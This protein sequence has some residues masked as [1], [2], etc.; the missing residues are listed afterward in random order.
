MSLWEF[1]AT[2]N[3]IEPDF[4]GFDVAAADGHIGKV[5][6]ASYDAGRSFLVVDTGFW[7]FG[8]KRLIPAGVVER[9]DPDAET[10]HVVPGSSKVSGAHKG[11]DSIL[12]M[13]GRLFELSG[14]SMRGAL[15]HALSDGGDRV[16][17]IHTATMEKDGESFAQKESLLITFVDGKIV[18]LQDFFEDIALNDRLYS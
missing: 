1:R 16:V 2:F 17:S 4:T 10:V 8:K 12:A 6:E 13:Y 5:D 15:E 3:T 18:E 14:G 11:K 9:V 7:I